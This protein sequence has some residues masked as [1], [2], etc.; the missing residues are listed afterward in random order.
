MVQPALNG[1][2]AIDKPAGM[3]SFDV[4]RHLRKQTGIRTFGHAGTLDP[5]ATGLLLIAVNQYTRLLSL[6]DEAEKTYEVVME[7]GK[8]SSTGDPEGEITELSL[9]VVEP[10]IPEDLSE[11]VLSLQTLPLPKYSAVKVNGKRAYSL[12]RA[13]TEFTL[14]ERKVRIYEFE[15]QNYNFPY[16]HYRCKVSKGT[17]IRSLSERIA[18]Q[19][20]TIAY[21]KELRRTAIGRLKVEQASPLAEINADNLV[22]HFLPVLDIIPALESVTLQE[23]DLAI[24]RQG[25]AV[26]NKGPDNA[27]VLIWDDSYRCCGIAF[28]SGQKLHPKVNL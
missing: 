5:F 2:L 25:Q 21:T 22:S 20:G 9:P 17:Y 3:T 4:I 18:E 16:L 11:K 24:L 13:Q 1:F 6:W 10:V 14:Q 27:K 15:V 8:S 12:A 28:R 26:W 7:L 19:L 23:K